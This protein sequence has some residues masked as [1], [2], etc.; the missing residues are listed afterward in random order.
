MDIPLAKS[1]TAELIDERGADVPGG[2]GCDD[3]EDVSIVDWVL[4]VA[5]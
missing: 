2:E 4:L 3:D 5:D 1:A